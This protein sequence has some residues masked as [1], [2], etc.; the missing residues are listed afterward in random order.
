MTT[1]ITFCARDCSITEC[2]RNL[3]HIKNYEGLFSMC[4]FNDCKDRKLKVKDEY[5]RLID[6]LLVDYD[7]CKTPRALKDLIDEARVYIKMAL[8]NDDESVIAEGSQKKFN[9]LGEVIEEWT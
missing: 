9:I 6:G 3:K 7:G 8:K 4:Y 2:Q 5:L 1:D